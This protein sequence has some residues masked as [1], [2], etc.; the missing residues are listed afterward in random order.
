MSDSI[1]TAAI[2]PVGFRQTIK[3]RVT[4]ALALAM[5]V[6]FA[7]SASVSSWQTFQTE[8]E[9]H[10]SVMEAIANVLSSQMGTSV[11]ANYKKGV[12]VELKAMREFPNV[13][14]A[15]V[16]NKDGKQLA[17]LGSGT[18]LA[19]ND[20]AIDE[21]SGFEM[22]G[23]DTI[24]VNSDIVHAGEIIG[25][26]SLLTNV[27]HIRGDILS[28]L[29]R[30]LALAVVSI[31]VA[32]AIAYRSISKITE[33]ISR[34][35]NFMITLGSE[36]DY[37]KRYRSAA[38]GEVGVLAA[39][40]NSM[41]SNIH[42]RDRELKDYQENLEGMVDTRT[43]Q[44]E[45]A[46][47]VA[48]TANK[49]K[50]EFLATMSHEIR[51]PMNGMMVMAEMLNA[52]PLSDRHR[53][54]ANVIARSGNS[55]LNIINDI[56]DISKIEAG[57]LELEMTSVFPDQIVEDVANLFWDKA[58]E[59]NLQLATYVEPEVPFEFVGDPTR[60][61]QVVT[62]LVNNALKFTEHGCVSII[63]KSSLR[64]Q[65]QAGIRIEVRDTGIGI[66]ADKQDQ[67]FERFSQEDQSTTRK[68]GGTGL[69]LA[70]CQRLV[71]AMDGRIGV[72]SKQGE[73]STFWVE[74][75]AEIVAPGD[76]CEHTAKKLTALLLLGK[77]KDPYLLSQSLEDRGVTVVTPNDGT[78]VN[79][80]YVIGETPLLLDY[81]SNF[82]PENR[83]NMVCLSS[84]G[85]HAYEPL[86]E[87]EMA[88]DLLEIPFNRKSVGN[89]VERMVNGNLRGRSL[90]ESKTN[91]LPVYPDFNGMRV[92][93]VDDNAVNR[94]VLRD[95]LHT[96]G[97]GVTLA[98][99][100]EDAIEQT[101]STKYDLIFMDCSMPGI[102][103]FEA[104]KIIRIG[105][106]KTGLHTPIVALTAHISG[107]EA[108]RWKSAGMDGYL[109]KPFTIDGIVDVL[110]THSEFHEELE[111]GVA[112]E[113]PTTTDNLEEVDLI[114][115]KTLELLARLEANGTAKMAE[116]IFGMYLE[117]SKRGLHELQKSFESKDLSAVAVSA[118][119]LK[120]MSHSAGASKVAEIC[121]RIET[122][123]SQNDF[124]CCL[125]ALG[126]LA[127]ALTQT[128]ST[129]QDRIS[130]AA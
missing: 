79:C 91:E 73:G 85:D 9:K 87:Q 115:P 120:S 116:K 24:W 54:Y 17:Q 4:A 29:L 112:D 102:D 104:T 94:E 14:F 62:N 16:K 32:M 52:A 125:D 108:E 3:F 67:I 84:T 98:V 96:L 5:F 90:L 30:N 65:G 68:F 48:E 19:R 75:D 82:T 33:P 86:I 76:R 97:A 119:S 127:D 2:S 117:H 12:L 56:L 28:S 64:S 109:A 38:K 47:I 10:R 124:E 100:G 57:K 99:N 121:E 72:E 105:E 128:T 107:D 74:F 40:F 34:L 51:T 22:L 103:G 45:N 129:M 93:A 15:S 37:E 114:N 123:A 126:L 81:Q 8:L 20:T 69:G 55:L 25:Q 58:N 6:A 80:D 23:Q 113:E 130:R 106:D 61:N 89:L 50:S 95:V 122:S 11:K 42:Q 31:F 83:P 63:V 7:V 66:A 53:R 101:K 27:S 118:H 26:L 44:L 49:A 59:N 46:K 71:E 70:I 1:G 41:M 77:D 110:S 88:G 36:K 39:S 111:I 78:S 35:S 60:L 21:V 92:L 43:E 13:K 18:F